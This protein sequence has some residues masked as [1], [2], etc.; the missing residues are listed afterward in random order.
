MGIVILRKKGYGC[1]DFKKEGLRVFVHVFRGGISRVKM[2]LSENLVTCAAHAAGFV[3][4][5]Q[6]ILTEGG[7]W[8]QIRVGYTKVRVFELWGG[9]CKRRVNS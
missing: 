5:S 3:R 2:S 4:I 9:V 8:K 6:R 7:N 1:W